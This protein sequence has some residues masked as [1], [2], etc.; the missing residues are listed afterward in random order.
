MGV[1]VRAERG[2][3]RGG[4]CLEL[5]ALPGAVPSA[6]LHVRH[7]LR[8]WGLGL[9]ADSSESVV[10]ELVANAVAATQA[11]G[12]DAPVR[13]ALFAEAP[14]AKEP[15]FPEVPFPEAPLSEL[16]SVLVV[17]WDATIDPP[18]PANAGDTDECGRG[19]LLVEA[20]S[21]RWDWEL[22]PPERGGKVVRALI[23]TP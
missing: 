18:V 10:A 23:D 1:S 9:L 6:R 2:V 22:S 12:L 14:L 20:L 7:V 17:V 15:P 13:L 16:S 8:E 3:Y 4:S 5:G 21:S 11:A 19:L